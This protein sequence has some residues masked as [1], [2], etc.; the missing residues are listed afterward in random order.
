MSLSLRRG[1]SLILAA[2][3]LGVGLSEQG[4]AKERS[5]TELAEA[6][7]I[8]AATNA[9]APAVRWLGFTDR[10][11]DPAQECDPVEAAYGRCVEL[12]DFLDMAA[13]WNE[14]EVPDKARR[15][16]RRDISHLHAQLWEGM[17][18]RW[19][20]KE[21]VIKDTL[22]VAGLY[23]LPTPGSIWESS[24]R[25][26]RWLF[27]LPEPGLWLK[28]T[29][30]LQEGPLPSGLEEL[31]D[32]R[33]IG[34]PIYRDLRFHRPS[35]VPQAPEMALVKGRFASRLAYDG[36]RH[37]YDIMDGDPQ[38]SGPFFEQ[39]YPY[40]TARESQDAS[41]APLAHFIVPATLKRPNLD[42]ADLN[43][44][45]LRR[46]AFKAV[47]FS[48]DRGYNA[49]R[50]LALAE[51]Q[52][53]YHLVGTQILRFAL[54]EYTPTHLRVLTALI[55]MDTPPSKLQENAGARDVVAASEGQTDDDAL[56]SGLVMPQALSAGRNFS[57]NYDQ[58]PPSVVEDFVVRFEEWQNPPPDFLDAFNARVFERL[59]EFLRPGS[60]P[61]QALD[62][63]SLEKWIDAWSEPGRAPDVSRFIKRIGLETLV[64][65]LQQDE[66]DEVLTRVLLDHVEL[67]VSGRFNPSEDFL[68]TPAD[69]EAQTATQ[70]KNVLAKHGFY[71]NPIPDGP[72]AVD[73][74]AICTTRD[75]KEA[76]S[77]PSFG[78]VDLDVIIAGKDE[79]KSAEALLWSARDTVPF[80]LVDDPS[81]SK[82]TVDRLV[83]L[84]NGQALYR[85]RWKVWSGWHLLWGTESLGE[86][87][88]KRRLVM[89]TA[90]I[91]ED[92]V[93]TP[94]DLIPTLVRAAMLDGEFRGTI[95]VT[96]LSR[97]ERKEIEDR[98]R[99]G[100]GQIAKGGPS[101]DEAVEAGTKT[102]EIGEEVGT[103]AERTVDL[104][105]DD[106][107]RADAITLTQASR[108]G[109]LVNRKDTRQRIQ[110]TEASSPVAYLQ[111][112]VHPPL[113]AI[114]ATQKSMMVLLYDVNRGARGHRMWSWR[115]R[116]PYMQEQRRVG[117]K[118]WMRV[119]LW[120]QNVQ[121]AEEV[122][123][124]T[125]VSP[126]W[127]PTESVSAGS[128]TPRWRR[129]TARDFNL[130]G[131]LGYFPY[132]QV[133]FS[134]PDS[135]SVLDDVNDPS[136]L[137]LCDD[138]EALTT[139]ATD[140]IAFDMSSLYDFWIL[141]QPRIA[142]EFG[143]EVQVLLL[144]GGTGR[145]NSEGEPDY[146][147]ALSI[148][149]GALAGL[150][151]APDPYPL[152]LRGTRTPWG[153]N[154]P[155]GSSRLGRFQHGLRVGFLLGAG[156]NGFEGNLT[157]EYWGGWSIRRTQGPTATFT[158]YRPGGLVGPYL[159]GQMGVVILP[160]DEDRYYEMDRRYEILFGVRGQL[161]LT[162]GPAALPEVE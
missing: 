144:P 4:H 40:D 124:H 147:P 148:R 92:T 137:A 116:S 72:G 9:L 122:G 55:A 39:M 87:S 44:E 63:D 91:C 62:D 12:V 73:P 136:T 2:G 54:E 24:A 153:A 117:S 141:D 149:A 162:G 84:P 138:G 56:I 15:A 1:S 3:L 150:R 113:E 114:A 104:S 30:W 101:G 68:A 160:G 31:P 81:T 119:A 109:G 26:Q 74:I 145:F 46:E 14:G 36:K 78:S 157:S 146:A 142:V 76:L 107:T 49:A 89:R 105:E 123:Y 108:L 47:S 110:V 82:P 99:L 133:D 96:G 121:V 41:L 134:C 100:R 10:S 120:A 111:S 115:P 58:L 37:A 140:G 64:E 70:W 103:S 22:G 93:I 159:R 18:Y 131:A 28:P 6:A 16:L 128:P 102:E 79:P 53:F 5:E 158:P 42:P 20:D 61:I 106:P 161:R 25:G 35:G 71:P 51:F 129:H 48:S 11:D 86:D 95:P 38:S 156:Y 29:R 77:E 143:P 69:Q 83:G 21:D 65:R 7:A 19:N 88:G 66:Q 33:I 43:V 85:V 154:A 135:E 67:D 52:R 60:A 98:E 27:A 118:D 13:A 34:A 139:A 127:H 32:G 8:E 57:I 132:R 94:P 125:L 17:A 126:A 112:L 151:F 23:Y 97:R 152:W 45:A 80:L 90:A 50:E 75:R 130:T 155:D 59:D